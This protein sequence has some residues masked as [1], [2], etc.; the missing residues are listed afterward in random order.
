MSLVRDTRGSVFVETLVGLL[1]PI[2]FF[3]VTWQLVDLFTAQL[4]LKHAAV[5]AARAAIVVGPDDPRFYG[6][7]GV[8]DFS[9]GGARYRD[10]ARAAALVLGA[11][12]NLQTAF[13]VEIH[14]A[15]DGNSPITVVVNAD[16]QCHGGWLSYVC[17][18]AD[19]R[20]L[21]TEA[22]MPYQGAKYAYIGR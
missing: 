7:Q 8:N 19:F 6:G 3:F 13:S 20:R 9:K 18:G 4:I 12:P 17:G 10:V 15:T 1:V 2:V 16:Y 11:A 22:T 5:A 21:T 14:G